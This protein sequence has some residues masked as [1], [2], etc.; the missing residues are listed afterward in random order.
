[1]TWTAQGR[2]QIGTAGQVE[3]M[4]PMGKWWHTRN[5]RL[6]G[7]DGLEIMHGNTGCLI[8]GISSVAGVSAIIPPPPKHAWRDATGAT[9]GANYLA[10]VCNNNRTALWTAPAAKAIISLWALSWRQPGLGSI[11][12]AAVLPKQGISGDAEV[13]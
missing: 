4:K 13:N 2:K 9:T 11:M 12:L 6:G 8:H 5:A 10:Y 3:Q 1:M 7:R